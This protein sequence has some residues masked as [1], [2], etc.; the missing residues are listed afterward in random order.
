[1]SEGAM[2]RIVTG[3]EYV[4]QITAL[5]SDRRARAA[6]WDLVAKIAPP[7][8][9]LLDFGAGPGIDA[10]FYAERGF[11]VTAYD[12]DAE[13][14]AY[15]ASHC[16]DLIAAGR[17]ILE[18]GTYRD[19]L[20]RRRA[21]LAPRIDL[22]TSNFAPFNLVDDL[23]ELFAAFHAC[24]APAGKLLVS[25]LSPYFL[26]DARYRWWWRNAPRLWCDGR[27]SLPG[28]QAA[29]VRRRPSDFVAQ[30]SPYF[31]LARVMP[32][33]P[34]RTAQSPGDIPGGPVGHFTW[35]RLLSCRFMFLL[36]ERSASAAAQPR[37]CNTNRRG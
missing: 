34:A 10:R 29:I 27:F 26:G 28:A 20:D 22:V 15:F 36:F 12:V 8:A 33:L 25:V 19:F 3:A 13:M 1:M 11:A 18:S 2:D 24:T 23:H 9:A 32:G 5:E 7:R 30:C 16:A 6:F 4:R 35:L 17:V 37:D 21:D 31:R 14:R